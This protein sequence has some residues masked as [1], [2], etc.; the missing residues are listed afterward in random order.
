MLVISCRITQQADA[1]TFDPLGLNTS[2]TSLDLKNAWES[3]KYLFSQTF[4][5]S[6]STKKEKVPSRGVA[7]AH[8]TLFYVLCLSSITCSNCDLYVSFL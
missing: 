1:S 5:S 6:S 2:D 3:V 4:E 8:I 7:G